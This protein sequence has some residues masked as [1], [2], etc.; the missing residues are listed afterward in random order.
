MCG[1]TGRECNVFGTILVNGEEIALQRIKKIIGFVP[2]DDIV[3]VD[4][5]VRSVEVWQEVYLIKTSCQESG[6][7]L[8]AYLLPSCLTRLISLILATFATER[9]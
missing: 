5:T 4:L 6:V 2:Q 3:H 7:S 9:T 8:Q 1:R